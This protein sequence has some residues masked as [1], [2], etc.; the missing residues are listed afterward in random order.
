MST[1]TIRFYE[2]LNDFLEPEKRKVFYQ[3]RFRYRPSV[4]HIIESQHIP[5]TEVD[6]ILVNGVSVPFSYKV[7]DGDRISVYPVF[8]SIDVSGA[9][10]VR[11]VPLRKPRF[12]LDVHLGKLA[13][14]LRMCGFDSF[15]QNSLDDG[16]IVHHASQERRI[17]L[18]RDRGL[19]QQREV[20]KGYWVRSQRPLLQLSVVIYRFVLQSSLSPFKY[21]MECNGTI[22]K[23]SKTS[24]RGKI[25]SDIYLS[26]NEFH[27]C[28]KC[29]KIYWKGSH[30]DRMREMLDGVV[31]GT[32]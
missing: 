6:L 10:R 17:I 15:Y 9:T 19:L 31:R 22:T 1:L 30:Y 16:E 23:T 7:H 13:R 18:T 2:E 8:E 24:L 20:R 21:C 25:D 3:I 32:G 29:G 14:Y 28:R 26:Y 11:A 12:I 5:H 27:R 4:K